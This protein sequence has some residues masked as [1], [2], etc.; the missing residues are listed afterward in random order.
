MP[1]DWS[2]FHCLCQ[3]PPAP[4]A[5]V[6]PNLPWSHWVGIAGV[7]SLC[8]PRKGGTK[9]GVPKGTQPH[10]H[11]SRWVDFFP[12]LSL[13]PASEVF[14][15][16][17]MIHCKVTPSWLGF[18]SPVGPASCPPTTPHPAPVIGCWFWS[19]PWMESSM[20]FQC[21]GVSPRNLEPV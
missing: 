13:L 20:P 12:F 19:S 16:H 21:D 2:V 10:P 15:A 11:L 9:D 7:M 4:Q 8:L 3:G 14:A 18:V 1:L 17:P 6:W 5:G